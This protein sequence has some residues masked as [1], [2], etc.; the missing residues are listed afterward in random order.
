MI[1]LL[2]SKKT[3]SLKN[4]R[5]R[6]SLVNDLRQKKTV[7]KGRPTIL[8]IESTNKCNLDCVMCP[9]RMMNRD[10]VDMPLSLFQKIL[11]QLFLKLMFVLLLQQILSF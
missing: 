7:I 1:S 10:E 8:Y 2:P 4:I 9:R 11:D 5:N 3:F 6:A